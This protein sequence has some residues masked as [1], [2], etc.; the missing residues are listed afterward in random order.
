MTQIIP[1]IIAKDFQELKNKIKQIEPFIEWAQLDV[2]DGDFVDNKTWNN[3]LDLRELETSLK[4]EAHLMVEKPEEVIDDWIKS[5]VKRIIVHYESTKQLSEIIKKIQRSGIEAGIA[6]NPETPAD[7]LNSLLINDYLIPITILVMTVNP[8]RGGQEFLEETLGKIKIL[9]EKYR[10]VNIEV[11]GGI[12]LE[13][14]PKTIQAG[15]NVLA[16][17]S[18]IFKSEDIKKTIKELKSCK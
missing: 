14:A 3:P 9:R 12:N 7:A 5:G 16:V 10:D 15:A 18:A 17:G 4:L 2:M 11:D 8:G 1:A 6:I 13:T